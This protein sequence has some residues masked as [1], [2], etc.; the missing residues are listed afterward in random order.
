MTALIEAAGLE[1]VQGTGPNAVAALRGV[2]MAVARG[3]LVAVTSAPARCSRSA[4]SR[5]RPLLVVCAL[6][7]EATMDRLARDPALRAQPWDVE[8]T[9]LGMPSRDVERLVR[10]HATE[11]AAVGASTSSA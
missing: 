9:P 3:E 1:R 4:R 8:V 10:E 11:A 6:G 2:D 7:I 5:W